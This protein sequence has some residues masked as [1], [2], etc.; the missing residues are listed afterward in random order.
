VSTRG[1]IAAE[2]S[3]LLRLGLPIAGASLGN[4]L[5]SVVD[6]MLVGRVGETALAAVGLGNAVFFAVIITGLGAMLG[7]D[8]LIAQAL[9]A[10]EERRARSLMWQGVWMACGLALPLAGIVLVCGALLAWTGQDPATIAPTRAF[11]YGRLPSILPFLVFAA[12]RSYLQAR[13]ATRALVFAVVAANLVNAPLCAL[14]LF[15]DAALVAV[16]LPPLGVPA[17]GLMGAGL[18][19]TA[20]TFVQLA[21]VGVALRRLPTEASGGSVRRLDLA[22][23]RHTLTL[24][25][26]IGLQML[27]EVGVFT[28]A[29][30]VMGRIGRTSLA[31]HQVALQLAS[32]TFMVPLGIG[33]AASVRVGQ[34]IGR[35]DAAGTRRAGLVAIG[36][37]AAFMLLC[38][39]LF[40]VAGEPLARAFAKDAPVVR[41]AVPLVAIA[42]FFQLSDGVQA[43]AS[44]ALRGAG[45][46]RWPLVS[47]LIGHYAIGLPTSLALAFGLG[48]GAPGIW[49]GLSAGLTGVAVALLARF[50]L[51]TR[52]P[53]ARV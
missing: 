14:L 6:T 7:L 3:A 8:P 10:G 17:L 15:G 16:D 21:V 13:G 18:A 12:L 20:A 5:L 37:G 39:L 31:A 53:V 28:L 33:S 45:D 49:W 2:L 23:V 42:A 19:S 25:A 26:P 47:N 27:A 9:G 48:W 52:R 29:S 4:I 40:V 38:A 22:T 50:L 46:T 1:P 51:L 11:L 34:A 36:T 43:V 41:A 24:G 30:I 32:T 44:G 35:G